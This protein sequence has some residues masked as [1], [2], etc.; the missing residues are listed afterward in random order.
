MSG[1]FLSLLRPWLTYT[2]ASFHLFFPT[3]LFVKSCLT[4][5]HTHSRPNASSFQVIT[6]DIT[7]LPIHLPI[8]SFPSLHLQ[9]CLLS[10]NQNKAQSKPVPYSERLQVLTCTVSPSHSS[11]SGETHRLEQSQAEGASYAGAQQMTTSSST[12]EQRSSSSTQEKRSYSSLQ[13]SS[14]SSKEKHMRSSYDQHTQ[15][16]LQ[17]FADSLSIQEDLFSSEAQQ[18]QQQ[19]QQQQA[20]LTTDGGRHVTQATQVN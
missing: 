5:A 4:L 9:T 10:D 18:Q 7:D 14:S 6:P 11:V 13:E 8:P 2:Y 19:Q 16:E 3:Q 1:C 20:R 17:K 15:Q 12:Q